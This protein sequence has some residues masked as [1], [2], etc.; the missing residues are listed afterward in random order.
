M[1]T[2]VSNLHLNGRAG[3]SEG[4]VPFAS[5]DTLRGEWLPSPPFG[6]GDRER[7]VY[8]RA[9]CSGVEGTEF[10]C[11][12]TMDGRWM[13]GV[14]VP[15]SSRLLPIFGTPFD[16]IVGALVG[17]L[18]RVSLCPSVVTVSACAA[19]TGGFFEGVRPDS[20][21]GGA[22]SEWGDTIRAGTGVCEAEASMRESCRNG[23]SGTCVYWTCCGGCSRYWGE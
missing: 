12:E 8:F 2:F 17:T 14:C 20:R 10:E 16:V 9:T 18:R 23:C 19:L 6:D 13:R 3:R 7:V 15:A 11:C 1:P 22:L 5:E 4:M 21:C